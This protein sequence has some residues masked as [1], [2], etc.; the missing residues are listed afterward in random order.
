MKILRSVCR[1]R[2]L[3]SNFSIYSET[4]RSN[5]IKKAYAEL[6]FDDE[7]ILKSAK[8]HIGNAKM[9]GL[10]PDMYGRKY[11]F[12]RDIDD[13]VLIY[14]KYNK[15]LKENNALDFDDLLLETLRLLRRDGET[16]D[17]LADK[18]KYVLVD[19][20]QDTNSVQYDI[21]KLLSSKHGNLF[22]V[23]DDDQSIYG[24]R[25]A[26]IDNILKFDKDFPNAKFIN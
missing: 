3:K 9:L 10:D 21:I 16:R 6:G 4:E 7:R 25:G 2:G 11:A 15:H 17:Y 12:E 22:A 14:E 13:V 23:G 5:I 18:F 26:E 19:E 24:W 8:Y 20:F 1:P